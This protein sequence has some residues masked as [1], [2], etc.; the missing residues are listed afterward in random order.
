MH[1]R[2]ASTLTSDSTIDFAITSPISGPI[3][4]RISISAAKPSTVVSPDDSTEPADSLTAT[5]I[6]CIILSG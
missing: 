4:K 1:G 5:A 6:A 2:N 3:L